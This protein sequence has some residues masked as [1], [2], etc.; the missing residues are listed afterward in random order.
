MIL[1]G[2]V[3]QQHKT[4][5]RDTAWKK[6]A[7]AASWS[8]KTSSIIKKIIVALTETDRLMKAVN[9]VGVE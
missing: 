2:R 6:T 1:Y 3:L 7:K 4:L 5:S 9:G 8:L